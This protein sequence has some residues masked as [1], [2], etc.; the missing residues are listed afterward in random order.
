MEQSPIDLQGSIRAQTGAVS[1][2]FQE[3]PLAILNNGT[4][5]R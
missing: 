4:P 2:A 5:F 3:T 1:P